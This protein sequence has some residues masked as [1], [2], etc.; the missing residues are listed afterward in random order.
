MMDEYNSAQKFMNI[1]YKSKPIKHN[2]NHLIL[3]IHNE[4][5]NLYI[6]EHAIQSSNNYKEKLSL[7]MVSESKI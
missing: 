4:P 2:N 3:N 6:L 1:Y 7:A 5:V